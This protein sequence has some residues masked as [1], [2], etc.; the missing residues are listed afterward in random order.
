MEDALFS[1]QSQHGAC[2]RK[3][4]RLEDPRTAMA[5][6]LKEEINKP[7]KESILKILGGYFNDESGLQDVLAL[8]IELH[9]A[10]KSHEAPQTL[11]RGSECIDHIY[12]SHEL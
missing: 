5:T 3:C 8:E 1:V 11:R 10:W 12:V 2:L 4:G 9:I 6:D 7:R